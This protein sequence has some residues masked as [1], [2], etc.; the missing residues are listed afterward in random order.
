MNVCIVLSLNVIPNAP[1]K[2]AFESTFSVAGTFFK[3]SVTNFSNA[4]LT[5]VA[6]PA[7]IALPPPPNAEPRA[8][9]DT[10]FQLAL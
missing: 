5:P 7:P 2:I 8:P 1:P 3:L 10:E 4:I 9:N 6:R